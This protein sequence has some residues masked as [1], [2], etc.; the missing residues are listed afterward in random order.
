LREYG[1]ASFVWRKETLITWRYLFSMSKTERL[2][3][4]RHVLGNQGLGFLY[5]KLGETWYFRV[6]FMK[7]GRLEWCH[8][9]PSTEVLPALCN[10]L[11]CTAY[12]PNAKIRIGQLV[13]SLLVFSIC[14]FSVHFFP[15]PI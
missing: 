9:F 15:E 6:L 13:T 2:G 1:V 12:K 11:L 4:G 8:C 14:V 10:F 7:Q 5:M 3:I